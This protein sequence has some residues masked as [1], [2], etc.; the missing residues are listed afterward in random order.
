MCDICEASGT[1]PAA[2]RPTTS[3]PLIYISDRFGVELREDTVEPVRPRVATPRGPNA[4]TKFEKGA[5]I[6][7]ATQI[8]G[9]E[10]QGRAWT[11]G[12]RARFRHAG[13]RP[14]RAIPWRVGVGVTS[15]IS[16]G[17]GKV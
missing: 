9:S 8:A 4:K 3:T 13:Q 10:S 6:S 12:R 11:F 17:L 1:G 14:I 15:V 7:S 2:D 16:A 5:R